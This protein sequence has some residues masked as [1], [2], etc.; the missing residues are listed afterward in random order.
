MKTVG[1]VDYYLSEWHANNYPAWIEAANRELGTDYQVAY[2]WAEL[3]VSPVDGISTDVWCQKFGAVRCD[4]V[5]ELCDKADVIMILAPSD[6][7]KHLDYARRVFPCGKRVYVDKTFAPDLATAKAIFA[8]AEQFGTPFFSTSA[9]RYATELDE[10]SDV[11]RLIV[12][13]G[14]G[15]LAEYLIHQVEMAIKL[16][17][18]CAVDGVHIGVSKQG[19]QRMISVDGHDAAGA[20]KSVTFV[21]APPMPF[22]VCAENGEGK[23]KYAAIRSDFFAA[24]LRD[25]LRFYESGE[26][27]FS[28]EETLAVMALREAILTA[29]DD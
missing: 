23:S 10:F 18:L 21:F 12:T 4:T 1:F 7:D 26:L 16:T 22:S 6:P 9:L 29:C 25:I 8:L 5:E 13:G 19:K 24:L 3:D 2:A 14:G 28:S 15:N 27:P 20:E 17:G 11:R